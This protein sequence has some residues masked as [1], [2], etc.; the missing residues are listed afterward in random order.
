VL[1]ALSIAVANLSFPPNQGVEH[2]HR[3][4]DLNPLVLAA[5][6]RPE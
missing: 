4:V 5:L 1:I 6:L 3:K 2:G